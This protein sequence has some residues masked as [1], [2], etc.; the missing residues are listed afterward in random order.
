MEVLRIQYPLFMGAKRLVRLGLGA[1][2]ARM[3]HANHVLRE[4]GLAFDAALAL[5]HHEGLETFLAQPAQHVDGRDVGVAG[6]SAG[7]LALR[8]DRRRGLP[9]LVFGERRLAANDKGV[10][11]KARCEC[12]C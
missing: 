4:L 1:D 2:M 7:V 6:G 10:A 9:H 8:E 11:R 5:R 3:P 12:G